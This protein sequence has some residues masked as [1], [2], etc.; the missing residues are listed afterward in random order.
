MIVVAQQGIKAMCA[1]STRAESSTYLC[2]KKVQEL[3][4]GRKKSKKTRM[5]ALLQQH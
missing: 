2:S 3:V 4:M 5:L 1:P